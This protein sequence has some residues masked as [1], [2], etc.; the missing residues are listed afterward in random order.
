MPTLHL[1]N[2][3]MC[4]HYIVSTGYFYLWT[5]ESF[6][7]AVITFDTWMA[8]IFQIPTKQYQ[9][10]TVYQKFVISVPSCSLPEFAKRGRENKNV[11]SG[12][13][14]KPG[15]STIASK[16]RFTIRR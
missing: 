7:I 9:D 8:M 4:G 12:V 5:S 3:I 16:G 15:I 14:V 13:S 6:I 2:F 1:I 10:N 11:M